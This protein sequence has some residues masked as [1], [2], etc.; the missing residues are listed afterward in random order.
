MSPP[1]ATTT[2]DFKS[3]VKAT[4]K[5]LIWLCCENCVKI[6]GFLKK[7]PTSIIASSLPCFHIVFFKVLG[8]ERQIWDAIQL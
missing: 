5:N 6:F 8:Q 7:L 1:H 4:K 2:K 3:Y